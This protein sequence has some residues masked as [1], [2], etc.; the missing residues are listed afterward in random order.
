MWCALPGLACVVAR[1]G[2]CEGEVSMVGGLEVFPSVS[3]RLGIFCVAVFVDFL[4]GRSGGW[5]LLW[6]LW[7]RK[8]QTA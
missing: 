2:V 1:L 5:W 6:L 8:V 3:G 4:N 7:G